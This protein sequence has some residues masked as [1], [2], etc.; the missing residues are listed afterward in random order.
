MT[1]CTACSRE[2]VVDEM[3]GIVGVHVIETVMG[4]ISYIENWYHYHCAD[5][6]TLTG[7]QLSKYVLHRVHHAEKRIAGL[8]RD[9]DGMQQS[10]PVGSGITEQDVFK[11]IK[12]QII[13]HDFHLH[14]G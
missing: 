1:T 14:G 4:G 7:D 13:L 8:I 5:P 6:N 12:D 10:I 9:I 2:L 11:L 3:I